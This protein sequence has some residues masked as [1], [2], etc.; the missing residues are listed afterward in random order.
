MAQGQIDK[1]EFILKIED[2]TEIV[3][4]D[5]KC[6]GWA[7]FFIFCRLNY[8]FPALIL[9]V[10]FPLLIEMYPQKKEAY[11]GAS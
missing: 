6:Y 1:F 11:F 10:K 7:N 2:L 4:R 3:H 8:V 9:R 5:E